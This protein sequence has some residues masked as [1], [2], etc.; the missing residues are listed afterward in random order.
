MIRCMLLTAGALVAASLAAWWIWTIAQ[1][2]PSTEQPPIEIAI[3]TDA[4]V[5]PTADDEPTK[6]PAIIVQDVGPDTGSGDLRGAKVPPEIIEPDLGRR[7]T[8]TSSPSPAA[9]RVERRDDEP[10]L[11]GRPESQPLKIPSGVSGRLLRDTTG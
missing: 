6:A 10:V 3:D 9:P 4:N 2:E 1:D 8:P 11:E 5:A 7:E